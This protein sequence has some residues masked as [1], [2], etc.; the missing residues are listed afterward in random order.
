MANEQQTEHW[1]SDEAGHWVTQQLRY[2]IMLAP[3]GDRVLSA[4][5][6]API[7]RVLDVGCG[8]GD[9]TLAAGRRASSGTVTGVDISKV[10]LEVARRRAAEERLTNVSFVV[11]DAQSYPLP[12]ASTDVVI[13]R[14]GLMFFDDPVAAFTNLADALAPNGR[15]AFVCWQDRALNPFILVPGLAIAEHITLPDM[16]PPGAPGMFALADPER[17]RGLLTASGLSDIVI[18]SFAPEILLGGGGTLNDAVQF[19]RHGGMGRAVLAGVNEAIQERALA[20]V[21]QALAPYLTDEG[22]RIGTA[23]WLVTAR[24]L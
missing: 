6:I 14:F 15:L 10:M 23:A 16:G 8:C 2:D 11:G 9:T 18:E 17:I 7:D 19:L 21:S 20:A 24:C 1:N 4:A 22:V 5:G 13:S 3:F 12:G